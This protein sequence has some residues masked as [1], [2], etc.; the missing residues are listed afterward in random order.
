[1]LNLGLSFSCHKENL[2]KFPSDSSSFF[3]FFFFFVH[4]CLMVSGF[5]CLHGSTVLYVPDTPAG[6]WT[7]EQVVRISGH[8]ALYILSH[9]DYPQ[10]NHSCSIF[11]P[12]MWFDHFHIQSTWVRNGIHLCI[13]F[14]E[15]DSCCTC[16]LRRYVPKQQCES[17]KF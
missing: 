13:T 3:F 11:T 1:M 5:Q 9:Q 7:G 14:E 17:H 10:V 4:L 2:I 12:T 15:C 16:Y 6:G 8:G